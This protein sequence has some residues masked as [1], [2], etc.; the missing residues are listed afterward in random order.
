M[1][2]IRESRILT[3]WRLEGQAT[4]RQAERMAEVLRRR[5]LERRPAFAA[6][7]AFTA[8]ISP[9][10]LAAVAADPHRYGVPAGDESATWAF[11][12]VIFGVA[13]CLARLAILAGGRSTEHPDEP[14]T[15]FLSYWYSAAF[16]DYS[17]R[18][19]AVDAAGYADVPEPFAGV[20]EP[21]PSHHLH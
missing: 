8:P 15:A 7:P 11:V 14:R 17:V 18:R 16:N 19:A 1:G 3:R 21:F 20:A 2:H 6:W 5:L 13:P 12:G 10:T 4:P 9:A